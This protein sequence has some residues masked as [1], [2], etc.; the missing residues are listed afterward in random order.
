[1]I[2]LQVNILDYRNVFFNSLV[3]K[4]SELRVLGHLSLYEDQ[5][6]GG[7]Q[8]ALWH[9]RMRT[10]R[11]FTNRAYIQFLPLFLFWTREVLIVQM[12][13]RILSNWP[14]LV[15]RLI[16]R[17]PTV[18]WG[19]A[20]SRARKETRTK[21]VRLL[22][23]KLCHARIVYT[24]SE[25]EDLAVELPSAKGSIFP[26]CNA[27]Y[28]EKMV[29]RRNGKV[30]KN[31]IYVGRLVPNKKTM[32]LVKAFAAFAG[33]NADAG[34][35]VVGDGPER[36]AMEAFCEKEGLT[37]R[38]RFH[39]HVADTEKLSVLYADAIAATSPGYAGLSVTQAFFFGV[40]ILLADKEPHAP[41][42]EACSEGVNT[43]CFEAGKADALCDTFEKVW[44]DREYWARQSDLIQDDVRSRYSI[45]RMVDAFCC[46]ADEA[47]KR[48][49]KRGLAR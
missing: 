46:A 10:L 36:L 3:E 39:G 35:D 6:G 5:Q 18:L 44:A 32:L 38:V 30:G 28:S 27:L 8:N 4:N 13:P 14:L 9:R 19:H 49:S 41:E 21:G 11:F 33:K 17:R 29:K 34:L 26:A 48:T 23:W 7:A 45:E 25:A 37:G 31:F 42:V 20:W 24:K 43:I 1:M 2:I 12:N 22:L 15:V 47:R 16:L 40:P